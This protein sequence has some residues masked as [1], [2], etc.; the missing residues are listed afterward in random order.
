MLVEVEDVRPRGR[1]V[2]CGLS[3]TRSKAPLSWLPVHLRCCSWVLFR[4]PWAHELLI[5]PP[6][7]SPSCMARVSCVRDASSPAARATSGAVSGRKN[8]S[9]RSTPGVYESP[10]CGQDATLVK[11]LETEVSAMCVP[12]R[13][14]A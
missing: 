4:T 10:L 12:E 14:G 3:P 13:C 1:F 9:Q 6:T 11:Q 8:S 7:A 5:A 2:P